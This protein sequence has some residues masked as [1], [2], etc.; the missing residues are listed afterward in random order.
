MYRIIRSSLTVLA[1]A[2]T[3]S[4]A[5]PNCPAYPSV[6]RTEMER[7]LSLDREFQ[8]YSK[9]ARTRTRAA[10][11]PQLANSAN[12]IDQLL[13]GKMAADAVEP[14]PRTNDAEFLRRIHLDLPGRIP[15]PEQ[16]ERFLTD[17]TADKRDRLIDELLASPA[18]ADQ[19]TLFFANRLKVT[20]AHESISTPARDAFHN[21]LRDS[22]AS[23]RPYDELVRQ[24]ITAS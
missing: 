12:F 3:L 13:S 19:F 15:T 17:A 22:E 21:L 24:L 18:Y 7:S 5:D 20:R 8:S 16:A 9:S 10:S 2:A 6:V 14:A 4:A 23:D 11:P 1:A